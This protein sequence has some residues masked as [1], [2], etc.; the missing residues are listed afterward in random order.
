MLENRGEI[1]TSRI[2]GFVKLVKKKKKMINILT[3]CNSS[4]LKVYNIWPRY[5]TL[6]LKRSVD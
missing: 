4:R 2:S 6:Q 3:R 1:Y 5:S